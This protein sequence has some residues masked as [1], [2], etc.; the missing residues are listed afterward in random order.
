M[1]HQE[2]LIIDDELRSAQRQ[3]EAVIDQRKRES[4]AVYDFIER[5]D[6]VEIGEEMLK[7]FESGLDDE[8]MQ[9]IRDLENQPVASADRLPVY[10]P[11]IQ[12]ANPLMMPYPAADPATSVPA[13]EHEEF[14]IGSN[15]TS[16]A[17]GLGA[18]PSQAPPGLLPDIDTYEPT[19]ISDITLNM[20][21][22]LELEIMQK[23][24]NELHTIRERIEYVQR[25]FAEHGFYRPEKTIRARLS[26][27]KIYSARTM[28]KE[29]SLDIRELNEELYAVPHKTR[30]IAN[31]L[32]LSENT[33]LSHLFTSIPYTR[34]E[35]VRPVPW[36][37]DEDRHLLAFV[38]KNHDALLA[39][40]NYGP[41]TMW[42]AAKRPLVGRSIGSCK[43]RYEKLHRHLWRDDEGQQLV[44]S[45]LRRISAD[46]AVDWD[47]VAAGYPGRS[48]LMCAFYYGAHRRILYYNPN[49]EVW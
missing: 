31:I 17:G 12:G 11:S 24:Y 3:A 2:D 45:V 36:N 25:E 27:G 21:S 32:G 47:Q 35:S 22:E 33:V 43:R 19:Y 7:Q 5:D 34:E 10:D 38:A 15:Q 18:G 14:L 26:T 4:K 8:V 44:Y 46:G 23:A 16:G 28:T 39:A 42:A 40:R 29:Q 30:Y 48:P 49:N 9:E 20:W 6:G 41:G 37:P 1:A 13:S